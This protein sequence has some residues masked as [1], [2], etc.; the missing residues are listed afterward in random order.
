MKILFTL[1]SIE[2]GTSL[3][4][5]A[6]KKLTLEI[7]QQTTHD[8]LITTNNIEH[9]A[10][11]QSER[12]I[13]RNNIG[14]NNILRYE[15]EFNFNLKYHAFLDIPSNYDFVIYLDCDIK[16]SN[17]SSNSEH[18]MNSIMNEYEF[19]ADR[20]HC[21]L[22]D[23]VKSYIESKHC[24]FSHKIQ[25]YDILSRFTLDDDVMNS[26]LPS[27]HFLIFKNIPEKIK[28]FSEKWKEQNEYLQNKGY[29]VR[30]WGDG[31]EIGIAARYAGFHKTIEVRPAY[32][33]DTLG[34]CFNGN[35]LA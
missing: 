31:F 8:V 28:L 24:L 14:C 15:A 2:A 20:L 9:F 34:L 27:E 1:L 11:I 19:G 3:Y 30:C 16:M 21:Y 26:Q 23:E 5:N 6:A 18:F 17:W 33:Q 7:L 29:H 4:L 25:S 10:D 12:C 13:I 22:K 35:K 32:W